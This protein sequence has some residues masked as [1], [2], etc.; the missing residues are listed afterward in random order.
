[1]T[2]LADPV[3]LPVD[4][5]AFLAD[6][7]PDPMVKM[8]AHSTATVRLFI[9]QAQAQFTSL[10]LSPR[11][12]EL[13]ILAVAAGTASE[14]V[15]EQHESIS[16]ATGV[17]AAEREM[18]AR[19]EFHRAAPEDRVLLEFTASVLAQPRVS[20]ELFAAVRDV[21]SDREIVEV[22][23]VCGYYWAFGRIATVLDV[24]TSRAA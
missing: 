13:V 22:L 9:Q 17:T 10:E 8:M 19:G 12:R 4:V 5:E 23:Q 14:F 20:D 18:I 21:L 2:R 15:A 7:P 24:P 6:Y 11:R 1:M 16:E 3:G